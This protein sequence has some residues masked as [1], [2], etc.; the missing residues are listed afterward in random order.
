MRN[1]FTKKS[2]QAGSSIL[3]DFSRELFDRVF[4]DGSSSSGMVELDI[5]NVVAETF[6]ATLKAVLGQ[7]DIW[8]EPRASSPTQ[9]ATF[10]FFSFG[11]NLTINSPI[12]PLLWNKFY[13]QLTHCSAQRCEKEQAANDQG[14]TSQVCLSDKS[15][16]HFHNCWVFDKNSG[17]Q[18]KRV[19]F[20][21]DI[22]RHVKFS[23]NEDLRWLPTRQH[24]CKTGIMLGL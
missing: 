19:K 2:F 18:Q 7:L 10:I 11:T 17:F 14:C 4:V 8:E 15:S 22:F 16:L 24:D 6:D 20:Q 13:T 12:A 5:L 9:T 3:V 1:P 23:A 21:R